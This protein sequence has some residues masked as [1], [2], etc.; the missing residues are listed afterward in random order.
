MPYRHRC[1]G[2]IRKIF[3]RTGLLLTH[4]EIS[5]LCEH[6]LGA[7]NEEEFWDRY[8]AETKGMSR[9][10]EK[11][12]LKKKLKRKKWQTVEETEKIVAYA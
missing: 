12:W 10:E 8:Y 9:D 11:E 6:V 4:A 1:F 2:K 5:Y 3:E 7:K